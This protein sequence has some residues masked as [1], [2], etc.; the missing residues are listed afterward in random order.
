MRQ[1]LHAGPFFSS[2]Y[3]NIKGRALLEDPEEESRSGRNKGF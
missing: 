3:A 1:I 2:V